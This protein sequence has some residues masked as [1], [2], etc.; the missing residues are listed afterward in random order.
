MKLRTSYNIYYV[1]FLKLEVE[2]MLRLDK[3]VALYLLVI[4]FLSY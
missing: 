4:P 1:K 3:L 2:I